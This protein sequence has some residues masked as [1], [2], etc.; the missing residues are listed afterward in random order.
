MSGGS[1]GYYKF[2]CKNFFTYNCG[3]W[4]WVNHSACAECVAAGRDSDD[5]E[6]CTPMSEIEVPVVDYGR[7]VYQI[8]GLQEVVPN[9][10]A[11]HNRSNTCANTE[12][13]DQ[14]DEVAAHFPSSSALIFAVSGAK[15]CGTQ[16]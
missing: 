3:N 8:V 1:G 12:S 14:L 7:L 4:V 15:Y 13:L 2:R 16:L 6:E 5:V 11:A 9:E 10:I